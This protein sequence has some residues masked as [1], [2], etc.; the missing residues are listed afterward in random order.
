MSKRLT[1]VFEDDTKSLCVGRVS[2]VLG[3]VIT[4]F[5]A[6]VDM[7]IE[8]EVTWAEA[9]LRASPAIVGLVAYIFT[10]LAE[11]KEWVADLTKNLAKVA[12]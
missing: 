9:V 3:L 1:E 7:D 6:T 11:M 8:T 10:R 4:A 2:L 5:T 12:K